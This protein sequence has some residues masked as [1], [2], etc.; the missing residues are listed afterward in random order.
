MK[1]SLK[2]IVSAIIALSIGMSAYAQVPNSIYH[3]DGVTQRQYLNPALTSDCGWIETPFNFSF[4]LNSNLG[5]GAFIRPVD[6]KLVT[7]MHP[8]ISA[9]DAMSK[10]QD[11]NA[12]EIR[13]DYNIL[14][15]GFKAWGGINSIGFSI[16]NYN[17]NYIPKD[18]FAFLKEGQNNEVTEYNLKN[19]RST[20][21]NYA[22]IA[23]GHTRKINNKLTVGA[24][25]KM[26]LGARYIQSNI[27]NLHIYMS[28][29]KWMIKQ[30]ST[31]TTSSSLNLKTNSAGEIDDAEFN[32]GVDGLGA[33]LDLGATYKIYENRIVSLD[34][35]D[36]GFINWSGAN[37]H[38]NINDTFEYTGFDNIADED[39]QK[40]E[41]AA[42]DIINSLE[43][44]THY[45]KDLNIA[46][47][48][49]TLHTTF[50]AGA[51]YQV[52]N[53]KISFGLLATS[54]IGTP[55]TFY[56][57]MLSVNFK[58]HKYFKAAI[59]GSLSNTHN[60]LGA[61]LTLGNFFIGA[62]YILAKYSKQ[63]IPIDAC[64]LNLA[65]GLSIKF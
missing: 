1:S 4:S 34:I 5:L 22:A 38:R 36:I 13:S 18:V 61:A 52:L 31:L 7:F 47:A 10:F 9:K 12:V 43:S 65:C 49:T 29:E 27:E 8:S 24:K 42:D 32:F 33:A 57:G 17:G 56:E 14:N 2:Y 44:L 35:T 39:S 21:Q 41:D 16:H 25:V 45:Q 62:D 58:P 37:L 3:L 40:F 55:K 46:S 54:R 11:M 63:F 26:L 20:E 28:G 50:R 15:V 60:S 6:E 19:L 59:N 23:L 64:K 48:T 53:N 51:E 30:S